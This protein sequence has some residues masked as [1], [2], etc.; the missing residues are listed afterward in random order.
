MKK[1]AACG[2]LLLL[3]TRTVAAAAAEPVPQPVY[4]LYARG[5][6]EEAIRAGEMAKTASGYALAA[7]AALDDAILREGPCMP[8]LQRAEALARQAIAT[9]PTDADGQV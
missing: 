1:I 2:L 3:V 9:D 6:Y 4:D 5:N 7:H 8:C